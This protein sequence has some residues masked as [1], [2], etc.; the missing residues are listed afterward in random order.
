MQHDIL[1][2]SMAKEVTHY[3]CQKCGREYPKWQGKCPACGEWNSLVE[4]VVSKV[5]KA[6][7]VAK[8]G[9]EGGAKPL[10][11]S[12]V[13][14]RKFSRIRTGV[15]ELDRVLGGGIVP[16]S[17]VLVAGEPGMGKSTLLTQLALELAAT[18]NQQPA[19]TQKKRKKKTGNWKLETGG[20]VIYVCGE[21][22][23]AQ[24]KM[25]TDRLAASRQPPAASR[26]KN[27][28]T[29]D[30]KLEAG[31]LLLFPETNVES[32]IGE[33]EKLGKLEE[34]GK[35]GEKKEKDSFLIIIDSI[36]T[37]FSAR[38]SGAAGSVGQV[39]ECAQQLIRLAKE[40][41][42][43]IFIVGHVTKEGT[44]A[45]PKILEH[46]AD[47]VLYLEGDKKHEF[48]ILRAV[49]N[50]FG[51]TDEV[52]VFLMRDSGMEEVSNPSDVFLSERQEGVAGSCV[53][54]SMQGLRPVLT[55]VQALVNPTNLNIPRRIGAGIDI[56]RL[57]VL[58]AVLGKR[59]GLKLS[60]KDVYVSVAG[61]LTL[62]EPAV[63]LGICLAIAS[64]Y[65]DKPLKTKTAAIGEVGLLG[66][67]R[68]VSFFDKRKKEAKTQGFSQII[69]SDRFGN[70][71]EAI[72]ELR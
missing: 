40:A 30:W 63:D 45:G 62:R 14:T 4:T 58:C 70:I 52:G 28:K 29:G 69:G 46:M 48:R 66:E 18:S 34:L 36:Q 2:F 72:K 8:V 41:N 43:P 31:D 57:Q 50:R 59:A 56:R 13:E 1:V 47:T 11:L 26:R 37:L 33:I 53:V 32:I 20:Q 39:R 68:K 71:R 3:I 64:S 61:G 23:P 49:K 27:K 44:I 9:K 5:A 60:D 42:I 54:V 15:G 55:E 7:R 38:L 25:R 6:G 22:S 19:T 65:K 16:G 21:E 10:K 35:F 67:I 12:E 51:S 17:V 24:V